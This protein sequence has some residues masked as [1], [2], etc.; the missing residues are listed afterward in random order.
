MRWSRATPASAATARSLRDGLRG[1]AELTSQDVPPAA[2]AAA[3]WTYATMHG[4]ISLELNGH[5]PPPMVAGGAFF[6]SAIRAMLTRIGPAA[7]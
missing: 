3:M 7:G 4:V 5:L 1:W 2:L 6:D